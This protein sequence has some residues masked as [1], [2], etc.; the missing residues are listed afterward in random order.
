MKGFYR[1]LLS[2]WKLNIWEEKASPALKVIST[3]FMLPFSLLGIGYLVSGQLCLFSRIIGV[4]FILG[5]MVLGLRWYD[6][7]EMGIEEWIE[8]RV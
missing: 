5:F 7:G 6:Q 2:W 1:W 8:K 4:V 3:L